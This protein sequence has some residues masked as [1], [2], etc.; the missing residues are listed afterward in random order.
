[1]TATSYV[2]PTLL[3]LI[4]G[5]LMKSVILISVTGIAACLMRKTSAGNRALAWQT[6]LLG[7][8]LLPLLTGT[9][10]GLP[11]AIGSDSLSRI[12]P[13]VSAAHAH[14]NRSDL[15][16][17]L[18]DIGAVGTSTG[19]SQRGT[20][21]T[22]RQVAAVQPSYIQA[23]KN[24]D[25]N[26]SHGYLSHVSQILTL[27]WSAVALLLLVRTALGLLYLARLRSRLHPA[28]T[29]I[30]ILA[31]E[32]AVECGVKRSVQYSVCRGGDLSSSPITW[33]WRHPVVLLPSDSSSWPSGKLKAVL[34]HELAHIARLDWPLLVI[35]DVAM[36]AYWINP[37]IWVMR[38]QLRSESE[39]ACDDTVLALGT[40]PTEYASLLLDIARLRS[41]AT[42]RSISA[43]SFSVSGSPI[44]LFMSLAIAMHTP[45]RSILETRLR[46]VLSVG[47]THGQVPRWGVLASLVLVF[48]LV[49][50]LSAARIVS[51][52][53]GI[54]AKSIKVKGTGVETPDLTGADISSADEAGTAT[55][56]EA[57]R[58][59]NTSA[60][61]QTGS[62]RSAAPLVGK[63][64]F[65]GPADLGP[66]PDGGKIE[67]ADVQW[68]K[69]KDGLQAGVQIRGGKR[70]FTVGDWLP[71]SCYIRNVSHQVIAFSF[72]A[73][74]F[75]EQLP[76]VYQYGNKGAVEPM[77]LASV[78][79]TGIDPAFT[80]ILK[81][82]ET[83]VAFSTGFGLG[84]KEQQKPG[85]P[86]TGVNGYPSLEPS[87]ATSGRYGVL[88]PTL[89][90]LMTTDE[91][92]E[93]IK[94]GRS[95]A[96]ISRGNKVKVIG[97]DGVQHEQETSL[98]GLDSESQTLDSGI[99]KFS[100]SGAITGLDE[101]ITQLGGTIAWGSPS[102][103]LVAGLRAP[104]NR[105]KYRFGETIEM[106][107]IVR[108]SET[109]PI[110]FSHEEVPG[111]MG[112]ISDIRDA[113]N[114]SAYT[115]GLPVPHTS[116]RR[117]VTL[118]PGEMAIIG[119]TRMGVAAPGKPSFED[120]D[121]GSKATNLVAAGPGNYH[122]RHLDTLRLVVDG[123]DS[124]EVTLYTG[125]LPL[126]IVH[127]LEPISWGNT[128][129]GLRAG[130]ARHG[131]DAR[132]VTYDDWTQGNRIYT[133]LYVNNTTGKSVTI[134]YIGND[135]K[136]YLPEL[137]NARGQVVSPD[138]RNGTVELKL[139]ETRTLLPFETVCIAHPFF[140]IDSRH[141]SAAR[142]N[143]NELSEGTWF[144]GSP[145]AYSVRMRAALL[146]HDEAVV[147]AAGAEPVVRRH[148]SWSYL[149]TGAIPIN[150]R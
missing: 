85:A 11:I 92:T 44:Q 9:L 5:L 76:R 24:S 4:S 143:L 107:Y 136:F 137:T 33:G 108:N 42:R 75:T 96:G 100:V 70:S 48:A 15:A 132:S 145:G 115:I 140:T 141:F 74:Y 149:P 104:N 77:K 19:R 22:D 114:K 50:P 34:L 57:D 88:Q 35:G 26:V 59:L 97:V 28:P 21:S 55:E 23:R 32:L 25:G 117:S 106:D 67:L 71:L 113:N 8:V 144:V 79:L 118:L 146:E 112:V 72:G 139:E 31:R 129:N 27:C 47:V 29:H 65:G 138:W 109:A 41:T 12:R 51:K 18:G 134:H 116:G 38:R 131:A 99:A 63:S 80:A 128:V 60:R 89:Y 105:Q 53:P 98:T 125:Y 52:N 101:V 121:P 49:P 39:Q 133:D 120:L 1:M 150:L 122:L 58:S 17:N 90:R 84:T 2:S 91:V 126:Q 135:D 45:S 130:L 14:A 30:Q 95:D 127:D 82:G 36:A 40:P 147:H 66:E 46:S 7:L 93:Q 68:G 43:L 124:A 78:F 87:I 37:L 13:P 94:K 20:S 16:P 61:P 69:T 110:T 73:H 103:G 123:A 54:V 3:F 148:Q 111:V 142:S 119:Q 64:N 10:P 6:C 83:V 102:H 81:P 86:N 56:S 62:L